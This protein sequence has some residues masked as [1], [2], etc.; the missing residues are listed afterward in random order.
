MMTKTPL[1]DYLICKARLKQD[2][3]P[4]IRATKAVK[5]AEERKQIDNNRAK[6]KA[7]KKAR[8]K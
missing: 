5:T 2:E 7:A 1:G 8:K 4:F 3:E 6:A